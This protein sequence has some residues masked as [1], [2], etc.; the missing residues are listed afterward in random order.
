MPTPPIDPCKL[1]AATISGIVGFAVTQ[2]PKQ[3]PETC[4]YRGNPDGS[5][6]ISAR[7]EPTVNL[8]RD[9]ADEKFSLGGRYITITDETGF[10]KPAFTAVK[11]PGYQSPGVI[12][13]AVVYVD[14]GKIVL[15]I[16]YPSGGHEPGRAHALAIAHKLVG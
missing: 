5:V 11:N 2:Q 1:S 6:S 13:D 15:R 3:Y 7:P 10:A 9:K 12:A 14:G 4:D 16:Y 8:T